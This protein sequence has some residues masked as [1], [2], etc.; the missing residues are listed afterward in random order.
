[1]SKLRRLGIVVATVLVLLL[2]MV[3]LAAS[4][5]GFGITSGIG[6]GGL[7]VSLSDLSDVPQLVVDSATS[8]AAELF[9]DSREK[10]DD[11]I[12]Q[13]LAVYS[14]AEGKDFVIVFNSGGWGWTLVED[15]PGWRSIFDGIKSELENLS[16]TL[17]ELNYLR[18]ADTFQGRLDEFGEVLN[19]YQSKANDL[20]CRVEFLTTHL[21]DLRV[22]LAGEST[23]AVIADSVMEILEDNPR[24][25]S[26]QTGP[27]F[28]H[29]TVM[30]E[31]TL[32]MTGNGITTDSLS[33]G[34]LFN[35]ILGY[36]KNWFGLSEPEDDFGTTPHYIAAP[37][38]DY[39]WQ[40]PEVCSR[41]TNF[42]RDNFGLEEITY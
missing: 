42:L 34:D 30:S 24:V 13:L 2:S 31:R 10:C 35:F 8:L 1:M 37:G 16:Y 39:W 29:Q 32:V 7:P 19:G 20:A 12:N 11:F 26:I 25:Y 17:L 33:Q 9:G 28:W 23:G 27:P 15:T 5:S 21:P 14:E 4:Y 36:Y 18:S 6:S 3:V 38:H 41:I 40:Y 22:I